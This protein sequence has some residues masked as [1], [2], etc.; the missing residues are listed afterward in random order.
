MLN[1]LTN[2][3]RYAYPRG[4]GGTVAITLAAEGSR[5]EP[6][7]VLTVRD[8]GQGIAPEHV[9]HIF[10]PFFTTGRSIG[11]TGL[12]LSIVRNM[13]TGPLQGTVEVESAVGQG[14]TFTVTVPQRIV[15]EAGG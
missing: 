12:G 5:A 4:V 8:F 10:E 6:M 13:V 14:T 7:Y 15:D 1:C 9:P 2:I 11:G 3:E